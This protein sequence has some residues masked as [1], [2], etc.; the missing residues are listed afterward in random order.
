[1]DKIFSLEKT[2]AQLEAKKSVEE[3][4]EKLRYRIRLV[5]SKN[6]LITQKPRLQK[7]HAWRQPYG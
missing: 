1:M 7:W 6:L 2:L 5:S 3:E 4:E